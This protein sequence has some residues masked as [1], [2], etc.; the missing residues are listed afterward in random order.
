MDFYIVVSWYPLIFSVK[1]GLNFSNWSDNLQPDTNNNYLNCKHFCFR[2][3]AFASPRT[4]FRFLW[5]AIQLCGLSLI[6]SIRLRSLLIHQQSFTIWKVNVFKKNLTLIISLIY[7]LCTDRGINYVCNG[8]TNCQPR[9][10]TTTPC[11]RVTRT[12]TIQ[13]N[14]STRYTNLAGVL[15]L[16]L[17]GSIRR[18]KRTFLVA[19]KKSYRLKMK[20]FLIYRSH[21]VHC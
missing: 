10:H 5:K 12:I 1:F 15:A 6:P 2:I 14:R 17:R 19:I 21:W 9:F 20:R 11:L 16:E 13:N 8:R 4:C 3:S 7:V 18:L